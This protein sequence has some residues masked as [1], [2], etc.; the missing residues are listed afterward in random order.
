VHTYFHLSF[1]VAH[2]LIAPHRGLISILGHDC[3]AECLIGYYL[4]PQFNKPSEIDVY[5]NPG[6]PNNLNILSILASS[7]AAH[8]SVKA[9]AATI[10]E[11]QTEEDVDLPEENVD[12]LDA[13]EEADLQ[14]ALAES[15]H[16]TEAGFCILYNSFKHSHFLL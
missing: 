16:Y 14:Q 11:Q 3:F 13:Q 15:R 9:Y 4:N 10:T 8:M 12:L 6:C 7:Q 1:I 5:H 2:V